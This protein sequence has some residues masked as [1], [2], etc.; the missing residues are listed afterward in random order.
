MRPL[1]KPTPVSRC[2]RCPDGEARRGRR[3]APPRAILPLGPRYFGGGRFLRVSLTD[4]QMRFITVTK[5]KPNLA[6]THAKLITHSLGLVNHA[7]GAHRPSGSTNTPNP[8]LRAL[9][10]W[11]ILP[12]LLHSQDGRMSWTERFKSAER[13][14]L[15]TI[16]PLLMEYAEGTA[17]RL[18]GPA[19]EATDAAKFE[20]AT[21]ACRHQG[22]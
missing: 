9:K 1:Y 6:T 18:R 19:R 8:L 21:S 17:T 4:I 14:D 10:L 11:C 20:R 5:V 16:L 15:T 7:L 3:G 2:S 13:G 22:G 12:A